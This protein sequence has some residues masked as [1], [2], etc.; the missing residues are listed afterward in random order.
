VT[1]EELSNAFPSIGLATPHWLL[2]GWK[3]PCF[4]N[5]AAAAQQQDRLGHTMLLTDGETED[6]ARNPGLPRGCSMLKP[7]G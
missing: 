3:P 2:R 6:A 1:G 4:L 5:P 7:N